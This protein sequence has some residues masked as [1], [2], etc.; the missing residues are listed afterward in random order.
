[1]SPNEC[2]ADAVWRIGIQAKPTTKMHVCLDVDRS[3][4]CMISINRLV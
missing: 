1:L 4:S 3:S 2:L